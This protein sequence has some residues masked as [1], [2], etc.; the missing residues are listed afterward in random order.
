MGNY[1][2]EAYEF[3]QRGLSYSAS[4]IHGPDASDPEAQR[5]VTGQQLSE[6]LRDFALMQYG[7]L[8]RMVLSKWNIKSTYDFGRIVFAMVDNGF[9]RKTDHDNIEDFRNVYDF[10]AA[11]ETNYRIESKI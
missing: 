8:A 11:F 9:M 2:V 7:L 5:H 3:V 1:P 4:R 6:G 10:L